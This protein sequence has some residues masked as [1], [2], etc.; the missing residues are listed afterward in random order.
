MALQALPDERAGGF[1][2]N[3]AYVE[4]QAHVVNSAGVLGLTP[5][6]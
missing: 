3:H 2:P 4:L 1:H 6:S 5:M